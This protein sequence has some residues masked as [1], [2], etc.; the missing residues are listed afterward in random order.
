M[1]RSHREGFASV[2]A[3]AEQ[4]FSRAAGAA[5]IGGNSIRLLKDAGENYPAWLAAIQHATRTIHFKSYIIH[6]DDI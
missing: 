1:H 3:L 6:D 2:R 5:L 4:A